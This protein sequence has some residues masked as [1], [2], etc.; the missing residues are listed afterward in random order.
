MVITG[1]AWVRFVPLI[2]ATTE[3]GADCRFDVQFAK[4]FSACLPPDSIVLTHNP[5]MWLLWGK[6]AVQTSVA[7]FNP[8]HVS[9]DFFTRYQGGVFFHLNYW[10]VVP[11]PNQNR[12]C[13]KITN[14]YK[15]ELVAE[16][17]ARGKTYALYR[18][19]PKNDR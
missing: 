7:V 16:R 5:N 12:F 10:C 8:E 6:N 18:L 1:L 17:H 14:T 19:F 13:Y 4:E 2:R 9:R 3:E 15:T 11:D